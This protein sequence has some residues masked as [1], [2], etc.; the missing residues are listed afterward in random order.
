MRSD[1]RGGTSGRVGPLLGRRLVPGCP[2]R[3]PNAGRDRETPRPRERRSRVKTG[4]LKEF[5]AWRPQD[6]EERVLMFDAARARGRAALGAP[7]EAVTSVQI[8]RASCRE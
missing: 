1:R 2:Q 5:L 4:Q 8:G 7:D 3:A 6:E